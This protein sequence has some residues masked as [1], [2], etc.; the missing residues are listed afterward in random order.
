MATT[1]VNLRLVFKSG[2]NNPLTITYPYVD[3][4]VTAEDVSTLMEAIIANGEIF[5]EPPVTAVG[6]EIVA[7]TTTAL[8]IDVD[9]E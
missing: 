5:S 4:E 3:P 7:K 6:A 9:T 1:T 8:A 2:S